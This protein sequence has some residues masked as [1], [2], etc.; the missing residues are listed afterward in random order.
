MK[1]FIG[2][3]LVVVL[4]ASASFA[5]LLTTANPI[6]QGKWAVLGAYASDSQLFNSNVTGSTI[7]GYVGYGLDNKSDL[8][9]QAGQTTFGNGLSAKITGY[10]AFLKHQLFAENADLPVS[11]AVGAGYKLTSYDNTAGSVTGGNQLIAAV[12]VSKMMLPLIPYG[13]LT[14]R[15]TNF[16]GVTMLTQT[17]LTVGSAFPWSE[18]GVIFVEYT[19]Q[20]SSQNG[21][22]YTAGQ[23]AAGV[24]YTI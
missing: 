3:L 23:I 4:F 15:G 10:G 8:L 9:I 20:F 11:I 17:D 1:N 19:N 5:E 22:N 12:G 7:G 24:G 2:V 16:N 6:G 13:G 21:L 14:Y 18:Q